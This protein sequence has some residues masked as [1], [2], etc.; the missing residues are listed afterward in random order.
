MGKILLK[1]HY[2]AVSLLL[3]MAYTELFKVSFFDN[4]WYLAQ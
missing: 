3:C 1:E 2:Y 4:Y